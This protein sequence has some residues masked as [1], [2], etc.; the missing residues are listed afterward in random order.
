VGKLRLEPTLNSTLENIYF[1]KSQI[2]TF[3]TN[4]YPDNHSKD[5]DS[6]NFQYNTRFIDFQY[7]DRFMV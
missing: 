3:N 1:L 2:S 4:S 5:K 7:N 6:I